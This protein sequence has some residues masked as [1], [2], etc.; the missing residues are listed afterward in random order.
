LVL[1][2]LVA[3]FSAALFCRLGRDFGVNLSLSIFRTLHN[4]GAFGSGETCERG[5]VL[6]VGIVDRCLHRLTPRDVALCRVNEAP[7]LAGNQHEGFE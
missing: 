7:N 6:G 3:I 2:D 5:L 1:E 4:V